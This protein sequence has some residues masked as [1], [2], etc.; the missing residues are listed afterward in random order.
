ME[1]INTRLFLYKIRYILYIIAVLCVLLLAF[2][3]INNKKQ[4]LYDNLATYKNISFLIQNGNKKA[5]TLSENY[6]RNIFNTYKIQ[7]DYVKNHNNVYQ[8]KVQSINALILAKVIYQIEK[9]G[10]KIIYL[11][12]Q[13]Y[14]GN[15]N[16]DVH[17][18]I[19]P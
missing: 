8:I 5:K 12:A 18:E 1:K 4:K 9:D 14:S 10:F 16:F 3:N 6:I 7:L 13:D 2:N 15:Q 19:S 11:K 17:M